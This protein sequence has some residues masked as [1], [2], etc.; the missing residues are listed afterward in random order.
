RDQLARLHLPRRRQEW[1]LSRA[2]L[3]EQVPAG[4][5]HS[6]SHSG[7]QVAVLTT[8]DDVAIGVDLEALRPRPWLRH[9]EIAFCATEAEAVRRAP[10]ARQPGLFLALWTLK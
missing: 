3:C 2:L 5:Y 9:A 8:T 1:L 7:G 10:P 4:Q 6:L